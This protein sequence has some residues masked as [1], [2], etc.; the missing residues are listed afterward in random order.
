MRAHLLQRYYSE[1]RPPEV[2]V[3][4][5]RQ[6]VPACV[7]ANSRSMST[8]PGAQYLMRNALHLLCWW[9]L[10]WTSSH[11]HLNREPPIMCGSGCDSHRLSRGCTGC[12]RRFSGCQRCISQAWHYSWNTKKMSMAATGCGLAR[13]LP[14]QA[15][16]RS[17]L[18]QEAKLVG[19]CGCGLRDGVQQWIASTML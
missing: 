8:R 9:V 10:S 17:K 12:L 15:S 2:R 18:V 14:A 19:T 11:W 5:N 6:Q 1:G 4:V 3:T 13:Y 16:K 7:P